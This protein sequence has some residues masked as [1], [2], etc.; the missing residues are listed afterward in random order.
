[1][2]DIYQLL[3]I[4]EAKP[5]AE[6]AF[7]NR[8]LGEKEFSLMIGKQDQPLLPEVEGT[9]WIEKPLLDIPGARKMYY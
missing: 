7:T 5:A 9:Y 6:P 4:Q 8:G 3:G 2:T 1:M